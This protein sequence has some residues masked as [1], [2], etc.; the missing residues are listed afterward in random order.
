MLRVLGFNEPDG[1]F[2]YDDALSFALEI[3]LYGETILEELAQDRF[4][5]RDAVVVMV[6]ALQTFIKDSD[7]TMLIDTLVSSNVLIQGEIDAFI[8]MIKRI[9]EQGF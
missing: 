3:D 7:V 6:N 9:D 1:D 8:E 4:M 2:E 5:R